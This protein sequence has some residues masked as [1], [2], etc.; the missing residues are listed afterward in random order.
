MSIFTPFAFPFFI[1]STLYLS[2]IHCSI[3][4]TIALYSSPSKSTHDCFSITDM[5]DHVFFFFFFFYKTIHSAKDV[6]HRRR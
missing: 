2:Y 4:V 1:P 5:L 6:R 3:Y